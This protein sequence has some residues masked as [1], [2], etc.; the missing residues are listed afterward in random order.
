MK[1]KSGFV[2]RNV[3]GSRVAVAVGERSRSFHGVIRLN[4]SGSLLWD[5]LAQDVSRDALIQVILDAYE[6]ER[7]VAEVDVDAFLAT[8][9]EAGVL[10]E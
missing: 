5:A 10:D 6:V 1:I 4:G 2:S 3:A 8:L 9:R 7:V